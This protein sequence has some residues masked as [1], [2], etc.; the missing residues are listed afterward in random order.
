MVGI[1]TKGGCFN[2]FLI[3][4]AVYPEAEA[5]YDRDHVVTKIDNKFY[6]INGVIK[7]TEKY[8]KFTQYFDKKGTSKLAL[9]F[10]NLDKWK[11]QKLE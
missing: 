5:W 3:L 2:F 8:L 7:N 9:E 4:R 10:Q 6:D 1:F 11:E